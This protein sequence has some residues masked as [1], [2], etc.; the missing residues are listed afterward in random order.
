MQPETKIGPGVLLVGKYKVTRELGRGGMAAV[1]EAENVSIGK[2][3][4]VK[5]LAAELANSAIVIERFFREARAAASVKSPYIVEVYDSGRL[6]D[7][8]P[9]IAM[10]LLEGESLYD[11]MA[12]VRLIDVK[13]TVHIIGQVAKG[14]MKAH[15]ANIVH[16]D[17]KPENI[18]LCKGEDGEEI[19]KILDFGLAKFYS[20]VKTDEKTARLTREGA[21]FGT[22][23]YMSPEQVKGQGSVDHRADLWALGCMTFECLTGRPVWN[24]DQGVAMTFAAIA[25]ALLPVPSRMRPDLPPS[26]DVWFKKALDRDPN[27]RF[28]TAKELAEE[29]AR[30]LNAPPI[31]LISVGSP[32]QM[33]LDAISQNA[34]VIAA[35]EERSAQ[36]QRGSGLRKGT[37]GV[38]FAPDDTVKTGSEPLDLMGGRD[39]ALSAIDLPPTAAPEGPPP[40]Q[41]KQGRSFAR[42]AVPTLMIAGAATAAWF[43]YV[44]VLHP[45][46][47]IPVPTTSSSVAA[48]PPSGSASEAASAAPPAP[49]L[50]KWV[51]T[52]E[53]GQA[54]LA[55]GDADGAM[56]KFKEASDS[57]A[58]PVAKS[59]L[60]QVKIG[61]A[62]TGP[63]KMVAFSH[64]RLGYGGNL[65][66]PAVAVTPKGAVVAWTD[67]HEQPGHDHVYSVL[68]DAAGRPTSRPRDLTPE[69]DY[70]MR[71]ELLSVDDKVILLFWDK[72][73]REPG[74]KLRWLDADGRIGGMSAMVGPQKS[75]LYWPAM[76]RGPDGTFW[77]V[78]QQNPDKEGDDIFLRHM[79][80]ELKPIGSDVRATDYEPEKGKNPRVTVP[81]IAVSSTNVFLAYALEQD[82]QH[83][84]ERMRIPLT[85]PDLTTGLQGTSKTSR[86]LGETTVSSED[87]VGGD[88][89]AIA[90]T[91]DA[92]FLVWHEIEKGAQAALLD[93]VKGTMLWRKRFAPRGGHPTVATMADGSA[94]V[95]YYESGRVRIAS[96]S[97]DGVS[98]TSTFAK[99]TGDQPRPWIAPGRVRGEWYVSWLDVEA[100]HTESFVAR[101]QCRN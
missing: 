16:R 35:L 76:D 92:C 38:G 55:G 48:P 3:L 39:P 98:T 33:E 10:E 4:A 57:G 75:G 66:R 63:C 59:F 40:S 6:E 64:P 18:H 34:D 82:K 60:D 54:A 46:S 95:A 88:Y 61:A 73:G 67:D 68:I 93:P 36:S 87:R 84:I 53:D 24:T 25:A 28:Q 90:C 41:A 96:V 58:G 79:D 42:V 15:A 51:A 17:L 26:F 72:S 20:P 30:A 13:S 97:R 83:L 27:K 43:V 31:S 47:A 99:V 69:A 5:V 70:A 94:E 49:E 2:K 44:K 37:P 86:Q 77:V 11:R 12:R 21:V 50:P 32:S 89:P 7:G 91:K 45:T 1:Y 71:P 9:F 19:A 29:L 74:V 65:G 80:A 100:G 8:R 62:T 85:S 78:W 101:M 81:S 23:A 56:R 22:P 52:I 14:L